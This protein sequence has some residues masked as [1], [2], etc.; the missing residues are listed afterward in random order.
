MAPACLTIACV[1][2][3]NPINR[4]S[5][6][7]CLL[8][9]EHGGIPHLRGCAAAPMIGQ[10]AREMNMSWIG[11][12][13]FRLVIG[14]LFITQYFVGIDGHGR[15]AGQIMLLAFGLAFV[16]YALYGFSR[17]AVAKR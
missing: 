8:R 4:L 17:I 11:V 15:G 2:Q 7:V 9:S 6:L 1:R 3:D 5:D 16:G 13:V 10:S 14:A 12:F